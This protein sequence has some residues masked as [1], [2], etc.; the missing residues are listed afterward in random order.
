MIVTP[1]AEHSALIYYTDQREAADAVNW[2]AISAISG[3]LAAIGVVLTIFY[4]AVQMQKNTLATHS[5]THHLTTVAL[6][7]TAAT[8]AS[9]LELSRVYRLGSSAP[10]QLSEDEFLVRCNWDKPVQNV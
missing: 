9:S 6:A 1:F 4:L 3:M 2:D 8:I 7:E 5:Q 10:D